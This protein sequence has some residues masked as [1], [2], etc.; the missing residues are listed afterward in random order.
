MEPIFGK[1]G[2][3]PGARALEHI[4]THGVAFVADVA[5]PEAVA[6]SKACLFGIS[7][8]EVRKVVEAIL[9]ASASG[10]I[11]GIAVGSLAG[12][13]AGA[14]VGALIGVGIGFT[15]ASIALAMAPPAP[16]QPTWLPELTEDAA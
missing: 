2:R 3:G 5:V 6:L 10:A 9:L 14:H 15:A 4:T 11:L 7:D 16:W 8:P 1:V 12:G 13:P